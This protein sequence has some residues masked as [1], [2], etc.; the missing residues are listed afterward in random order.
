MS[1]CLPRSARPRSSPSAGCGGEPPAGDAAPAAGA[2][3]PDAAG[4][5]LRFE[6]GRVSVARDEVLQL[7]LLEELAARAGFELE[8]GAVAPR[9][10]T[11]QLDAVPLLD[12]LSVILEGAAFEI[13]YAVDPATGAHRL[14][15]LRIGEPR[16][17]ATAPVA[18]AADDRAAS[19]A[20]GRGLRE[21]ARALRA[22]TRRRGRA[23]ARG[24]RE[25]R[26]AP[27]ARGRRARAADERR[28]PAPGRG[29]RVDRP[30]R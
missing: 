29:A 13:R 23:R 4:A 2:A 1:R 27:R 5:P 3:S 14:A 7:A 15:K 30:R 25:Q 6:N 8:V 9:S 18:G 28:R 19:R 11:L 16:A 24:G 22:A 12:A 17:V 10:L 26:G 20:R 21:A